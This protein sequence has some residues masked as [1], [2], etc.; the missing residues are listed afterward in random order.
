MN[1]CLMKSCAKDFQDVY[2]PAILEGQ[3]DVFVVLDFLCF[4]EVAAMDFDYP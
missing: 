1:F 3:D 2:V 4:Q